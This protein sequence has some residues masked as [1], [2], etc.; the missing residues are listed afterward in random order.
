MTAPGV[1]QHGNSPEIGEFSYGQGVMP[2]PNRGYVVDNLDELRAIRQTDPSNPDADHT[3]AFAPNPNQGSVDSL[4]VVTM[5]DL[6]PEATPMVRES[7]T[8]PSSGQ[9]KV[10]DPTKPNGGDPN[11]FSDGVQDGSGDLWRSQQ[12]PNPLTDGGPNEPEV[13]GP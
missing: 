1:N 8:L 6:R 9:W 4:G 2:N 12:P 7:N 13:S 3:A 10:I 11:H 5:G